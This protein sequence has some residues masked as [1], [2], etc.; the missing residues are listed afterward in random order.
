MPVSEGPDAKAGSTKPEG[1]SL[2]KALGAA[3]RSGKEAYDHGAASDH[4][5]EGERDLDQK[6]RDELPKS[7]SDD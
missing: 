1:E 4:D 6:R 3:T 2:S 5:G 7:F